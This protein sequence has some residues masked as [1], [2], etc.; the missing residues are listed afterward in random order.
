MA[1]K[2]LVSQEPFDFEGYTND[3]DYFLVKRIE[4]IDRRSRR[5]SHKREKS[6]TQASNPKTSFK[7]RNRAVHYI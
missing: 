2:A 7:R 6:F 4:A 5:S 1:T 3:S